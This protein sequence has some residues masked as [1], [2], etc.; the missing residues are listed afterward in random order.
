MPENKKIHILLIDDESKNIKSISEFLEDDGFIVHSFDNG[1]KA[2]D[3][4]E[5]KFETI[6]VVLMDYVLNAKMTGKKL[7][8][9]IKKRHPSLPVIVFSGDDMRGAL[10]SFVEGAITVYQR[11]I[12]FI[13]LGQTIRDISDNEAKFFRMAQDLF[14]FLDCDGSAVWLL[15]KKV[16]RLKIKAYAGNLDKKYRQTVQ[17]DTSKLE[18]LK[19]Y[20][21]GNPIV[22]GNLKDKNNFI[23][24]QFRE[25]IIKRNW[26]EII[27]I[28]LI[29]KGRL[30]GLIDV[31]SKKEFFSK[32][33]KQLKVIL[34]MLQ[35]YSRQAV[36]SISITQKIKQSQVIQ[37][38]N[39]NF[40]YY[41]ESKVTLNTILSKAKDLTGADYSWLSLHKP[42]NKNQELKLLY[43]KGIKKNKLK[44]YV[45]HFNNI[46]NQVIKNGSTKYI[47]DISSENDKINF[48]IESSLNIK[49]KSLVSI[50]LKKEERTIGVITV[51]SK[52]IEYFAKDEIDFLISLS[53]L[54]TLAIEQSKLSY[55][56]E[57]ITRLAQEN[58]SFKKVSEKVVTAVKDLTGD[59]VSLWMISDKMKNGEQMLEISA[60]KTDTPK[61]YKRKQKIPNNPKK[62]TNAYALEKGKTIIINDLHNLKTSDPPFNRLDMALN[63]G[64][65]SFM[66]A[67]LIGRSEEH[68][69]VLSLYS[70]SPN[71]YDEGNAKLMQTF[72]NQVSIAF[73]LQK[74]RIALKKLA[75]ISQRLNANT[76]HTKI[77]MEQ[78]AQEAMSI[79]KGNSVI[80][81]PFNSQESKFL[82][83]E[84]IINY[85]TKFD[86]SEPSKKGLANLIRKYGSIVIG[87][88][89]KNHIRTGLDNSTVPNE[90]VKQEITERISKA[91][92]I[93]KEKINALIGISLQS[94]P[95]SQSEV[96]SQEVGVIYINFNSIHQFTEDELQVY[97]IFSNLIANII[98]RHR[99]FIKTENQKNE[100]DV[101]NQ[102][103]LSIISKQNLEDRLKILLE[104]ATKLLSG[105]GGKIY[106]PKSGENK[107]EL[108]AHTGLNPRYFDEDTDIK[109][110]KGMAGTV[111]LS[112]KSLIIN[113]YPTWNKAIPRLKPFFSSVIEVPLLI[114]KKSI[115][116]ISVFDD[117]TR[118]FDK[119]NQKI[120]ESIAQQGA[121]SIHNAKLYKE[122]KALN[123]IG[124]EITGENARELVAENIL[125]A[126]KD[127]ASY[128]KATIQLIY[129]LND[130]RELI[131]YKGFSKDKINKDKL[132]CP[133]NEDDLMKGIY[134]KK[135]IKVIS[136][137][138]KSEEWDSTI[139]ETKDVKSWVG[140]PLI[141]REEILG[142]MTLDHK[143]PGFFV[144][145][146]ISEQLMRFSAQVSVSI[147]NAQL[148][149]ELSTHKLQFHTLIDNIE[150]L[151]YIKDTEGVFQRANQAQK[152]LLGLKKVIDIKGKTDYNFYDKK[153]A[154]KFKATEEEILISGEVKTIREIAIPI[155]K[156]EPVW[157]KTTKIPIVDNNQKIIGII[158]IGRKFNDLF[159]EINS[160]QHT[161]I[162]YIDEVVKNSKLN[163]RAYVYAKRIQADLFIKDYY[164]K[165]IKNS[166]LI[167]PGGLHGVNEI[168]NPDFKELL[169]I[170]PIELNPLIKIEKFENKINRREKIKGIN[171]I[172]FRLIILSL[173]F[174]V[175]DHCSNGYP[176]KIEL[177]IDSEKLSIK[178][179]NAI[180]KKGEPKDNRGITLDVL[181]RFFKDNDLGIL[182]EE[183][184]ESTNTFSVII[185]INTQKMP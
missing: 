78:I 62:C 81:F 152:E 160:L 149:S 13:D 178:N 120:L 65:R 53:A 91:V 121:L 36:E 144:K 63:F 105:K 143:Y 136:N 42:N 23:N 172:D 24:L 56:L 173:I 128:D 168:F 5:K 98:Y 156:D 142:V 6:T 112:K 180:V 93:K 52:Y 80:I 25:E 163:S 77:L 169:K 110:G 21:K 184:N 124:L 61:A 132:L 86:Y 85:K 181:K 106:L 44:S 166:K 15:D 72:A 141:F 118:I 146:E 115:G 88:I 16:N 131:A 29:S 59:S 96:S 46:E 140:I 116:V 123:E 103:T 151:I 185:P 99:L 138:E 14:N 153:Q 19:R 70:N 11:P 165:M 7:F 157:L 28:P 170:I 48:D 155:D 114:N 39:R 34:D 127:V 68:I 134:E 51:A 9:E 154:D 38:I 162:K 43:S 125:I 60:I 129:G 182:K 119:N 150:D 40:L 161:G 147:R 26:L 35:I 159:K 148:F 64:W 113:D 1:V 58:D 137:T 74:Q 104:S 175:F 67:P 183:F 10:S 12:D 73:Q 90:Q 92:C 75:S 82:S 66:A 130:N 139:E 102:T 126:L 122:L 100:L 41:N 31:Y 76:P 101:L 94:R 87:N 133:V 158:G 107:L 97:K 20:E 79:T 69:G 117:K 164:Y 135:E 71:K 167:S 8:S 55:Y 84:H 108:V 32:N 2:L 95:T 45:S 47:K 179:N 174:N 176:T 30:R 27:S 54:S 3:Y 171:S 89:K 145:E 177:E 50:P 49:I 111:F 37:D 17:L 4:L 109:I 83:K 57:T 22:I 18:L 33:K